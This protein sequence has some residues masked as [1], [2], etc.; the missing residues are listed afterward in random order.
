VL[1]L[2]NPGI[3]LLMLLSALLGPFS[4]HEFVSSLSYALI[5]TNAAAVPSLFL[6][7]QFMAR[8][9]RKSAPLLPVVVGGI[10]VFTALGCLLA[11]ATGVFTGFREPISFWYTY[12]RTLQFAAPIALVLGLAIFFYLS[13]RQQLF[14]AKQRLYDQQ[15][16]EERT[17]KLA[18][19]ARLRS[20]EARI[21]PHFLFN[22]LNSISSLIA[23]DPAR[24]EMLVGRLSALLRSLLDNT[25][26]P[27]IPLGEEMGI[28]AD[29]VEIEKARAG[30][31]LRW[32]L[33]VPDDLRNVPVPPLAVQSLVENAVKHGIAAQR[34]GGEI[35]VTASAVDGE[36]RIRVADSGPGFDLTAVRPGHGL[37][38]LVG[39]LNALFGERAG[40]MV[41]CKD[42][43][44]VVE[45]VVPR[46]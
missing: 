32:H 45:I 12:L 42:G 30:P 28:V 17:R 24:A 14:E 9:A 1:A 27:L 18:L 39:R 37:D 34:S 43:L 8:Q 4:V 13:M 15:V 2:L 6:L 25:A 31:R 36:A 35:S 11:E 19:E 3:T 10:I 7:P 38:N 33:N 21:H 5:N 41:D 16:A 26:V 23:T 40:L 44:N 22:T 20:L 46:Q 29:Y